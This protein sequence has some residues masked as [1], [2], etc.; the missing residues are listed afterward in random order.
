[1]TP[2]GFTV[3]AIAYNRSMNAY[4]IRTI[5]CQGC[6]QTVTKRLRPNQAFCSLECYRRSERPDRRNG[7]TVNCAYCHASFYLPRAR[8]D[9]A[10]DYFCCLDH[11]LEWQRR[12]QDTYTC[13]ICAAPFRWSPSR[14][15][16]NP[17]YCSVACRDRDPIQRERLMRMNQVQ[18]QGN[19]TTPERIGYALLD[20][21]GVPYERQFVIAGKFCVDAFVP[22]LGIV[23]QFDG[24]YWHG[25][26]AKFATLDH[27]QQKRVRLDRS[28]DAYMTKCGYTVVRLWESDLKADA[29]H[30]KFQLQRLLTPA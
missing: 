21:I 27:R 8:L 30:I 28:Q 19:P 12:E 1:M 5:T 9:N 22:S 10:S 15:A 3:A 13:K 20:S 16:V 29:G 14:K 25:N 7:E 18:Q 26:P 4:K 24:D 2:N 23:V 11:Q 17:V 6:G